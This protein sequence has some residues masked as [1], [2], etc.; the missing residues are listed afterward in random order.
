MVRLATVMICLRTASNSDG[1]RITAATWPV[2]PLRRPGF[3]PD[4]DLIA[5]ALPII[6]RRLVIRLTGPL[7]MG[8]SGQEH[9]IRGLCDSGKDRQKVEF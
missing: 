1:P 8:G 5:L 4:L 6:P 7:K 2:Y 9:R 3:D